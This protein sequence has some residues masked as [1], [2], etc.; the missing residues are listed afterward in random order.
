M[1]ASTLVVHPA[2]VLTTAGPSGSELVAAW[3]L[4]LRSANTRTAY[5]RDL[6]AF[7]SWCGSVG[8][9][10]FAVKRPAVDAYREQLAA[11]GKRPTTV[12]RSLAALSSFYRYAESV[13]AVPGNPVASVT[14]PR[15]GE[16]YVALTPALSKEEASRL[17]EAARTPR[18]RLLVVLLA[19]QAL[20][21]SEAL[22]LN[23][24]AVTPERGHQTIRV[25]GK[26]GTEAHVPLA[27]LALDALDAV[28][29]SE[30]RTA[31]PVLLDANGARM[32]RHSAAWVVERLGRRAGVPFKVTPHQLR[33]TAVTVALDAG[34]TLRDVQDLARH[35]NPSTTRRYDRHRGALDRLAAVSGVLAAA[36]V[37]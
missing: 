35:A 32:T 20:R 21:V 13:G 26:G 9:D 10:A 5:R 34:A 24:E 37:A 27:P 12:A 1:S 14:R 2:G 3:L 16:G 7:V 17:L 8:V 11:D 29:V 22:S 30:G 31:G 28:R 36:L 33:A 4:S 15:T 25:V 23:L 19:V 6:A 18:E